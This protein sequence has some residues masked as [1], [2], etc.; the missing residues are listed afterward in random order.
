MHDGN[1]LSNN[2]SYSYKLKG[3][4]RMIIWKIVIIVQ[5]GEGDECHQKPLY[6]DGPPM[7]TPDKK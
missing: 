5:M 6:F 2:K 1:K 7:T 4:I 3:G